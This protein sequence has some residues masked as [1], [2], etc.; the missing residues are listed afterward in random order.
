MKFII[1]RKVFISML[2]TGL[3]LLGY[4]SY[5]QLP[6][7]LMPNAELPMLY[8]QISSRQEVDPSY[9]EN[10]AVIPVEGA[11]AALE[12]VEEITTSLNNRQA[13]IGVSFNKNVKFK[14][15][16]LKLQ[17]KIDQIR[18][19]LPEGFTV[20]VNRVNLQQMNNQFMELQVRG[21]GGTD[22]VRNIVDQEVVNQL[23]NLDGIAAVN[24][25][26]GKERTIE[27]TIDKAACDAYGITMAGIRGALSSNSQNR[28]FAGYLHQSSK[29][30]FVH[31]TAEYGNVADIQ[32]IVLAEGPIFLKDVAEVYFGVKEETT[33]SRVNGLDA[34]S[35]R[36]VNDSQAN[37][38]DLSHR[39]QE[40][41]ASLNQKL[42]PQDI[43]IV[44]QSNS[45][46]VMEKNIDQIVSLALVGGL[47]AIFVLWIFL[48]NIRIVLII[49]LA[50]PVSV[51]S[52]F[53]FFYAAGISIN[54]LTLVGMALAVG[55][56]LDNSVVVLEN[57][58]RLAGKNYSHE[59]AVTQGT[60]EVWRSIVAA[61]L[62]TVT[63]FVPFIFSSNYMIKL[64]GN[65]I[66]VSI[67][68]TLLVSLAVALML[69][70]MT[71]H[72]LLR[73]KASDNTFFEKVTTNSRIIQIYIVF[74]KESLR[75]PAR[76][77]IGA[78]VLFF[79]SIFVILATSVNNLREVEQDRFSLYVTMP[80]GS[81]L[82]A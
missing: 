46:E 35:I 13:T 37:L 5:K 3:T 78:L 52:A 67:I 62:T 22:R 44:I 73:R 33:I 74:L 16:F 65:H 58:Y 42:D 70:P 47:L 69:V 29:R 20:M 32:N 8:V 56:L 9:M 24:V 30:Y 25:Y 66:G 50:I 27:V 55:M 23:G 38:I 34:I 48:K 49:A 72:S 4:I 68:S 63:V 61:T 57:I 18:D 43:E 10:Q 17:E 45:A 54:S 82:E 60:T 2:F 12:G 75:K 51:F 14:Y 40:L 1:N 39:A 77:I 28:T 7:E 6:I 53:N 71:A 36:L 59:R 41:I 26:G 15:I 19:N 79:L 21:S 80:T 76:T 64:L 11:I 81:T 31:V